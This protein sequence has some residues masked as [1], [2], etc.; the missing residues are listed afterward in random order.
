MKKLMIIA[1]V[2]LISA[3]LNAQSS[4][5]YNFSSGYVQYVK[6]DAEKKSYYVDSEGN[7][8]SNIVIKDS[9]ISLITVTDNKPSI[10]TIAL[11]DIK[12]D[13]LDNNMTFTLCGINVK[14]HKQVKIGFWF[15]AGEL[16][17][18]SY[19]DEASQQFIAYRDL[20]KVEN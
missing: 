12:K 17:Q 14:D 8:I 5:N 13:S 19:L 11:S 2:S 15:I 1:L 16:D 9:L 20:K 6:Y 10:V 18:V 4:A 7:L 3:G